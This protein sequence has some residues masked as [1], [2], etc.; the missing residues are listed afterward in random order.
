MTKTFG[1]V[2]SVAK[3]GSIDDDD[4]VG[5]ITG[6]GDGINGDSDDNL[7]ETTESVVNAGV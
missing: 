7:D 6:G 5:A 1:K 2:G 3:S 4:G